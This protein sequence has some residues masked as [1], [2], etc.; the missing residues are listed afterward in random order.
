MTW[1]AQA[2]YTLSGASLR[3]DPAGAYRYLRK[4][5]AAAEG[6]RG[7]VLQSDSR[8]DVGGQ[9]ATMFANT[10]ELL[11]VARD[12]EAEGWPERPVTEAFE[13]VERSRSRVF[14]EMLGEGV[15]LAPPPAAAVLVAQ[16]QT[17]LD[18]DIRLILREN[19]IALAKGKSTLIQPPEDA[20]PGLAYYDVPLFCVVHSHPECWF[21]W[22]RLMIDLSPTGGAIIRDMAPREIRGEKPVELKTSVSAG[23]KFETAAKVLSAEIK[24]EYTN[25]RTIYYPEIVS[26]GPNFT[27]GYWDFLALT[28]DYLHANRELRLLVSAPSGMPPQTRGSLVT[29]PSTSAS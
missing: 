5:L 6:I 7:R 1:V 24:P 16:E 10:V 3:D 23:L 2:Y 13:L 14:L 26:A 29:V 22:A 21:R 27:R 4:A 11:L 20:E 15:A 28:S 19:R 9:Y 25:S 8:R 17:A 12:V 18:Q